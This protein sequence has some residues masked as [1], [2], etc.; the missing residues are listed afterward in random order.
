MR[1]KL[2]TRRAGEEGTAYFNII[3]TILVDTRRSSSAAS[4]AP[5]EVSGRT[6]SERFGTFAGCA[7]DFADDADE[8]WASGH[9]GL[10]HRNSQE[11]TR[12]PQAIKIVRGERELEFAVVDEVTAWRART[13]MTKEPGTIAWLEEFRAGEVLVDVGA[14]VGIYSLY[15]ARFNDVRVF[16]FEP[17]SQNFALLN[18]NIYRNALDETV[19]AFC[20]ALSNQTQFDLLYL[21]QFGVGGSCHTFGASLSPDLEPRPSPFRQGCFATTLDA[22]VAEGVIPVPQHVKIDVDGIEH[23]VVN[24]ADA[25]FRDPRVKSVLIELNSALDEHWE[26]VDGMLAR[27]FNYDP[28]E[29]DRARRHEGPFAGTGNYVFR[30]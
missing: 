22:L 19:T 26:V 27:G 23:K 28:A 12:G 24:G 17:E 9:M 7:T 4:P 2:H 25:T 29:A 10:D 16:A 13:A 8:R 11:R 5:N 18:H 30:R 21:T 6:A 3:P 14:N 20:V 15:A 1:E